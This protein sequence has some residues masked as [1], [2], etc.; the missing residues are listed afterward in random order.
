MSE[1]QRQNSDQS[2]GAVEAEASK[3]AVASSARRPDDS[4]PQASYRA[5]R[6]EARY[7]LARW[8]YAREFFELLIAAVL[9]AGLLRVFVFGVYR[10]P[11]DGMRPTL[12][13]GDFIVAWKPSFGVRLP[14]F[15]LALE[16][17]G[18]QRGEV[19]ILQD[20]VSPQRSVIKRVIAIA[21]DKIE[22]RSGQ[23]WL[24]DV[25]LGLRQVGEGSGGRIFEEGEGRYRILLQDPAVPS[26]GGRD[27]KEASAD[28]F[29]LEPQIIPPGHIFLL[30]DQRDLSEDSRVWG[31]VP[32]QS[33][34][35]QAG[36]IWFSFCW[37]SVP[38]CADS[39]QSGPRWGR[40]F[41]WVR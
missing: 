20:P 5:R 32:S 16:G 40:L 19:V 1:D 17:R 23:I 21:G 26:A 10:I 14:I 35:A 8:I 24:N 15:G 11:G 12:L 18:A 4:N 36:L 22:I 7:R 41:S 2:K 6:T 3:D 39:A 31:P 33:L 37:A 34:I 9:V 25:S 13:P 29:N 27:V 28:R 38:E 30:G